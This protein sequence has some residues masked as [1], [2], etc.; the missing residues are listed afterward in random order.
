MSAD[1]KPAATACQDIW[2]ELRGVGWL[3]TIWSIC[4]QRWVVLYSPTILLK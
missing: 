1:R 3:E 4:A 2:R